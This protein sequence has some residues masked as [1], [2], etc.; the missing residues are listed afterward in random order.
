[1][2]L[3]SSWILRSTRSSFFHEPRLSPKLLEAG[4]LRMDD[5]IPVSVDGPEH[6]LLANEV[7]SSSPQTSVKSLAGHH[8]SWVLTFVATIIPAGLSEVLKS[9]KGQKNTRYSHSSSSTSGATGSRGWSQ[10]LGTRKGRVKS[11]R[12]RHG[13]QN[14]NGEANDPEFREISF[15]EAQGS[16]GTKSCFGIWLR[17]PRAYWKRYG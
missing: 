8:H 1:M 10:G 11:G 7:G 12:V 9:H 2:E 5:D 4:S 6:A 14:A 17:G 3:V 15:P 16:I 13:M